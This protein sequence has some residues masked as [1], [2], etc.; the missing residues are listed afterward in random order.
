[1]L[2][3]ISKKTYKLQINRMYNFICLRIFNGQYAYPDNSL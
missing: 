3:I 1:M 2:N